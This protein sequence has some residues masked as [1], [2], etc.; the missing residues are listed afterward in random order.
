[1]LEFVMRSAG[2]LAH[3]VL[4]GAAR[5]M[6]AAPGHWLCCRPPAWTARVG[7]RWDTFDVAPWNL[8]NVW[9]RAGQWAVSRADRG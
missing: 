9:W 7:Q 4:D 2:R 6:V 8:F 3:A 1:M 5:L